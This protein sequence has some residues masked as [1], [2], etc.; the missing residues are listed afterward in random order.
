EFFD[1]SKPIE[2]ITSIWGD[3]GVGKTTLALQI[4]LNSAKVGKI[5]F[6]YSK[7]NFPYEK[8]RKILNSNPSHILNNITFISALNFADLSTSVLNLELLN[9]TFLKEIKTCINLIVIDSITD[10]YRLKLNRDKKEKN[11]RLNY[12][13]NQ[14]LANLSYINESY[15]T[16]ILIVNEISRKNYEDFAIE[17]QSG[18]KV[19]DYWVSGSIKISRT[20]KLNVRNLK[21]MK[22]SVKKILKVSS[23][24]SENGFG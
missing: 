21:I 22:P 18:G 23:L 16:E 6:I 11:V 3:F 14:I 8:V 13:L 15:G 24:L 9:L 7:P 17:I 5:V 19:M 10:L 12:Q 2:G 1:S 20:N 4:A